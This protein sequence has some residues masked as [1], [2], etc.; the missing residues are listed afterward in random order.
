MYDQL[1]SGKES[2]DYFPN[3]CRCDSAFRYV[4]ILVCPF[5][6]KQTYCHKPNRSTD[7]TQ[8]HLQLLFLI[9]REKCF[10]QKQDKN[11]NCHLLVYKRRVDRI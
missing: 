6:K 10:K 11:E 4:T 7:S 2:M 1:Q 3:A 5:N 9:F 8:Q